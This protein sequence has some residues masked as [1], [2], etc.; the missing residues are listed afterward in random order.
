[1]F[2]RISLAALLSAVVLMLWGYVFWVVLDVPRFV[3]HPIP[4]SDPLATAL[5]AKNL[6][7]GVYVWPSRPSDADNDPRRWKAYQE[8]RRRGPV[9]QM[10]YARQGVE[11]LST[12]L[13]ARGL[14]HFF[15]TSLLAGTLLAL[16]GPRLKNYRERVGFV[17][18]LGLF[19]TVMVNLSPP[20]WFH[21]PWDYH[22]LMAMV[23]CINALLM[24]I[25]LAAIVKPG[26][27]AYWSLDGK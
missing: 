26:M 17:A 16:V 3:L 20:I 6:S 19:A 25:V 27:G 14:L 12:T 7:T 18:L 4:A 5:R 15:A 10:F 2:L 13:G 8:Q 1:M 11:L 22:L 24:G 9:V 21:H 23:D